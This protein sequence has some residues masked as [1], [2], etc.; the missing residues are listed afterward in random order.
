MPYRLCFLDRAGHV[1]HA[2]TI[3]CPSNDHAID[4]AAAIDQAHG[5]MVWS[6]DLLLWRFPS[7]SDTLIRHSGPHQH[8]VPG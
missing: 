7:Y 3:D 5:L 6:G 8:S 4:Y 2:R 1:S